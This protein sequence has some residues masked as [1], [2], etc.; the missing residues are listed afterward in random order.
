MKTKLTWKEKVEVVDEMLKEYRRLNQGLSKERCLALYYTRKELK[1]MPLCPDCNEPGRY[2]GETHAMG[3]HFESYRCVKCNQQFIND[4][5]DPMEGI[6][7]NCGNKKPIVDAD[8]NGPVYGQC[9]NPKCFAEIA[10]VWNP[11]P[12][13]FLV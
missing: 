2:E 9:R 7:T 11:K 8:Y 10:D 4:I 1:E 13:V 12:D 6:C 5:S 3:A